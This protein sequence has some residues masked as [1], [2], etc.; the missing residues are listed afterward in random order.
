MNSPVA[1]LL[2][3]CEAEPC[4]GRIITLLLHVGRLLSEK[5]DIAAAL[6][7]LLDYMRREMGMA[8]GMISLLHRESGHVFVYRS[9]GMT[10]SE[11]DR[12]VYHVGEGIT[13]KVVESAEPIIVRR[14][15]SEPAFLNRTGSLALERDKDMSFICVPIRHGRKV[16][17][18]IS[19][20]RLYRT[21]AAL[22]QHVNVLCLMAQM[23]AH[24]VELYLVENIDK[25]EWE[26]RTRLL[27]SDLKERF[28]PSNMI[29][30]SRPMQDVYELIRKVSA[31][32]TTVL[33][34][35]ESG[36]GK[37]MVANALHYGGLAPG[38]PFVKCNCAALPES[39]VESELFGHEKGSFT[40]AVFARDGLKRPTAAR[41]F[42]MRWAS[43]P[44]GCRPSCCACC[45]S[46]A[47]SGW[48]ATAALP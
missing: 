48:V 1:D 12:G 18:A 29:G 21:E 3:E 14:V 41:F 38:G 43:C 46:A 32:R 23:L 39:I 10:P 6:D 47:L 34:L 35:G 4:R 31:T 26:K 13:G 40:G 9:M 17:G 33:L 30:I 28:H 5:N 7:S 11:Q 2:H 25:V 27:L 44:W 20:S 42:W 36:V 45:K 24:A 37:E 19:A 16:L 15:G 8:R 22:Q